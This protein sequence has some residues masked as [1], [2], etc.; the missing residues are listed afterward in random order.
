MIWNDL[1]SFAALM[2]SLDG[3]AAL[4]C[5]DELSWLN[6]QLR[7]DFMILMAEIAAFGQANTL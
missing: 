4:C 5:P 1:Q 3:L 7:A 2:N 6:L